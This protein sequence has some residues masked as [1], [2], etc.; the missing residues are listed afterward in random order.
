MSHLTGN[1]LVFA[2]NKKHLW[3]L[4]RDIIMIKGH[5]C[6]LNHVDVSRIDDFS[7]LFS[8]LQF[9]GDVSK[10]NVSRGVDFSGMFEQSHFDGDLSRWNVSNAKNMS[11]MFSQCPFNNNSL[12]FWDVSNVRNMHWMFR[13]NTAFNQDL[14]NWNTIKLQDV[15]KM[16][17]GAPYTHDISS[18]QWNAV[19][20]IEGMLDI[21]SL[22]NIPN[23]NVYHWYCLLKDI[24]CLWGHPKE[25]QLMK[26]A[27]GL[28]N[29]VE[30]LGLSL[31]QA[32][33]WL[34]TKW[35]APMAI[36]PDIIGLPALGD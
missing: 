12:A 21:K 33:Q 24:D 22:V 9:T 34:D 19:S 13:K 10:W 17:N 8:S 23:P 20:A 6:D 29:I 36:K 27:S 16:F 5:N 3:D 25:K 4:V 35:N 2:T 32:A 30:G 26:H 15:S 11:F 31:I 1:S 14:K 28:S 7:M 18:W